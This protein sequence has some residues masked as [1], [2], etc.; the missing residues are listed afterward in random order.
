LLP[1]AAKAGNAFKD[2]MTGTAYAAFLMK[3]RRSVFSF[4]MAFSPSAVFCDK[5]QKAYQ[6]NDS[7]SRSLERRSVSTVA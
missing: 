3:S 2:K 6:S 7:T 5:L 4:A 1:E